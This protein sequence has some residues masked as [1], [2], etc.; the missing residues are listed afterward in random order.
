MAIS[1]RLPAHLKAGGVATLDQTH[2]DTAPQ[3][4]PPKV[5]A[6][7]ELPAIPLARP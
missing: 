6:T 2:R 4:L 5:G 1:S 3:Y 7:G